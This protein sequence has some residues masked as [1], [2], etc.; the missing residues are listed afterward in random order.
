MA[1]I[2]AILVP[3]DW[4][5]AESLERL[6]IS[7]NPRNIRWA[8]GDIICRKDRWEWKQLEC[9]GLVVLSLT[10]V[11]RIGEAWTI[12]SLGPL[13]MA[14]CA[15]WERSRGVVNMTKTSGH[16]RRGGCGSLRKNVKNVGWRKTAHIATG[17]PRIWKK[18]GSHSWQDRSSNTIGGTVCGEEGQHSCGRRVGAIKLSC[19]QV[20]G[21]H[22]QWRGITQN[23]SMHGSSWRGESSRCLYVEKM[24]IASCMGTGPPSSGGQHGCE[25]SSENW[26]RRH[27]QMA[28]LWDRLDGPP[29]KGEGPD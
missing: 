11:L 16:G 14:N 19:S 3:M 26:R 20:G 22:R 29:A 10:N 27:G 6:R 8:E 5:F 23:R 17:H 24:G 4:M 12:S 15:S 21:N 18:R 7:R 1:I 13:E 28:M 25:K 9:L 2:P